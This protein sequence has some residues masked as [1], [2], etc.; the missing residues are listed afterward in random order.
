MKVKSFREV[1]ENENVDGNEETGNHIASS[2]RTMLKQSG[3]DTFYV[4]YS[5]N[6]YLT[7]VVMNNVEKISSVTKLLSVIKRIQLSL[8]PGYE[9]TVDLW[10]T[11]SGGPIFTFDFYE[12][13]GK[14]KEDNDIPF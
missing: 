10:E 12:K 11:K 6:E 13:S 14:L 3:F 4:S 9:A 5:K 1:F 8:L 2:I 7:E